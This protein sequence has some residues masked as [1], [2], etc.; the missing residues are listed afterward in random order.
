MKHNVTLISDWMYVGMGGGLLF[1][2]LQLILLVDFTHSWNAK[3]WV[4]QRLCC[5]MVL[6]ITLDSWWLIS[7]VSL[8]I[9]K[10]GC[11]ECQHYFPG[12]GWTLTYCCPSFSW[13]EVLICILPSHDVNFPFVSSISWWDFPICILPSHD[14]IFPFVSPS[15]SCLFAFSL[16]L[17]FIC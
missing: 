1:I 10:A 2:I 9:M 15:A 12:H 3:W 14:M 11:G 7:R 5:M 8:S 17:R 4:Q 6:I 13:C 16:S